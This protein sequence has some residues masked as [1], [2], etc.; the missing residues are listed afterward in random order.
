MHHSQ[1]TVLELLETWKYLPLISRPLAVDGKGAVGTS[2]Y[3]VKAGRDQGQPHGRK[4]TG[5]RAGRKWASGFC[6]L[7]LF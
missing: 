3:D 1:C 5:A 2:S 6:A 7:E 4:M